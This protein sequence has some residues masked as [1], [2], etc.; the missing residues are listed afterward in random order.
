M[1]NNRCVLQQQHVD[2]KIAD[3]LL[4]K[5]TK[6]HADG[7]NASS[8]AWAHMVLH[9]PHADGGFGGTFND[10]TKVAAF[11]HGLWPGLVLSPRNVRACGCPRMI[12]GTHPRGHRPRF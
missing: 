9:L 7:W 5:G 12:F 3:V 8:K 1:L 2:F 11:Y 4:K 10:V 6:Q